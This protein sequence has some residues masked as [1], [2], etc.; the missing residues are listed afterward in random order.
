MMVRLLKSA[1]FKTFALPVMLFILA[2]SASAGEWKDIFYSSDGGVL[3]AQNSSFQKTGLESASRPEGWFKLV[4]PRNPDFS[5]MLALYR[6]DCDKR[7]LAVLSASLHRKDGSVIE[8]DGN[9]D[10][11]QQVPIEPDTSAEAVYHHLCG[12]Y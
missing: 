4:P 11:A 3:K 9:D 5:Y 8:S 6:I 12:H 10:D 1:A 7:T 2:G